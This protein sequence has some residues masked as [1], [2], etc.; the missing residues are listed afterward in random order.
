MTRG[1]MASEMVALLIWSLKACV[2]L[3]ADLLTSEGAAETTLPPVSIAAPH[4]TTI[5]PLN[6]PGSIP[7][8]SIRGWRFTWEMPLELAAVASAGGRGHLSEGGTIHVG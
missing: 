7:R 5:V 1:R 4:H 8:N 6:A 2:P 3:L